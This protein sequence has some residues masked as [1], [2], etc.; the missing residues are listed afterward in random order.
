VADR[1]KGAEL[2]DDVLQVDFHSAQRFPKLAC[3]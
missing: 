2:F 3:Y 1:F